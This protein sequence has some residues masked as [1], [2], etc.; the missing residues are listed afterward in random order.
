MTVEAW[1]NGRLL[2]KALVD[3]GR[4]HRFGKFRPTDR[5]RLDLR[6]DS[7]VLGIERNHGFP[8]A[9][10][11]NLFATIQDFDLSREEPRFDPDSIY[12]L[13][14]VRFTRRA[15]DSA[16]HEFVVEAPTNLTAKL[17]REAA[18]L[19]Y[20]D[21]EQVLTFSK[22]VVVTWGRGSRVWGNIVGRHHVENDRYARA[23]GEWLGNVPAECS[24]AEALTPGTRIKGLEVSFAS[25][26]LRM[27]DPTRFA[28]LDDVVSQGL[29]YALNGA[30]Y[31]L[32]LHDLK[33]LKAE[34]GLLYSLGDLEGGIF[35]LVRQ[36]VRGKD[37]AT[38]PKAR[39]KKASRRTAKAR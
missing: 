14:N 29:G 25:K 18:G 1:I 4:P 2:Q 34:H 5:V 24:P 31:N 9:L 7:Y 10:G 20:A 11:T 17:V 37:P 33:R 36:L 26:H 39:L 3:L 27:R 8:F 30:G 22:E 32:W 23:L 19:D 21:L 6:T 12:E 28:T 13:P 35:A 38:P 16:A 15:L